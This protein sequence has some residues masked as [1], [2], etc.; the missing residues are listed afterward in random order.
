[1]EVKTQAPS[2]LDVMEQT[3]PTWTPNWALFKAGVPQNPFVPSLLVYWPKSK[4]ELGN[5]WTI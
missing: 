4:E 1:V 2:K 5:D 3:Q